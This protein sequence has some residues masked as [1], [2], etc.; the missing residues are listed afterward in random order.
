MGSRKLN[1]KFNKKTVDAG[2]DDGEIVITRYVSSR[3]SE[4]IRKTL[5]ARALPKKLMIREMIERSERIR[6][7]IQELTLSHER[8]QFVIKR[9]IDFENYDTT[10]QEDLAY[11]IQE[12]Y[13][14]ARKAEVEDDIEDSDCE[15]P[16]I[17]RKK[18]KALKD[19]SP[20]FIFLAEED[21]SD[22]EL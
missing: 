1:M 2:S 9:Y 17:E 6:E 10:L 22:F 3:K 5:Q 18:D 11:T 21:I 4:K 20:D 19:S 13:E 12:E 8:L 14:E 16:W 7:V 15:F